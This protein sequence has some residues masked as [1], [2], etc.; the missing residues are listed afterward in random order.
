[1]SN[2]SIRAATAEDVQA[3]HAI[4]YATEVMG[5][6]DPPPMGEPHPWLRHVLRTGTLLVAEREGVILGF[7]GVIERG[8]LVFLTDLFVAPE[9]QSGGIG[10]SLLDAIL[11]R[12]G[13]TLATISSGDARAQALYIR[14]GMTP[15]WPEFQILLERTRWSAPAHSDVQLIPARLMDDEIIAFDAEISGRARPEEHAYWIEDCA[16][17]PFWFERNGRRAGYGYVRLSPDT[18]LQAP[19]TA[20]VGPIGARDSADATACA[21]AAVGWAL[22]RSTFARLFTPGPHP[23]LRPLLLAGGAIDFVETFLSS[24]PPCTDA[25]RYLPSDSAFF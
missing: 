2:F 24:A 10:K 6:P 5:E 23:A 4:W 20:I 12:D 11:P 21:L 1:M 18:P 16:G 8:N 13:R 3:V 22:E 19:D 14:S 17:T 7:A 25:T 9:L 15:E